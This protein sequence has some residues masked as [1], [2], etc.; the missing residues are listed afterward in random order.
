MSQ[1][2]T[3]RQIVCATMLACAAS[4]ANA[5]A[6]IQIDD[7][8]DGEGTNVLTITD[9]VFGMAG[10][11][12][13]ELGKVVWFGS[14]GSWVGS[15]AFATSNRLDGTGQAP[16]LH[17]SVMGSSKG[18]GSIVVSFSDNDFVGTG[19]VMNF[20]SVVGGSSTT[21]GGTVSF[22][23]YLD[24]ANNLSGT[25]TPLNSFSALPA[26][27]FS[28][29]D[30]TNAVIPLGSPYAITLVTRINHLQAG[31][32][33]VDGTLKV[34]EPGTLSLLGAILVGAGF[35]GSRRKG[36]ADGQAA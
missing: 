22:S 32:T 23:T 11:L 30:N 33:S 35:V 28:A 12:S 10:D 29:G 7:L 21:S 26:T 18:A 27:V 34:P 5:A 24:A 13:E 20:L 15:L 1:L 17:L 36:T 2:R 16:Q 25:S 6:I 3:M 14:V 8:S 31:N 4:G 19:A 9:N